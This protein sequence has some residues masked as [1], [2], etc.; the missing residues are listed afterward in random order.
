MKK[1]LPLILIA[2]LLLVSNLYSYDP[3]HKVDVAYFTDENS[4]DVLKTTTDWVVVEENEGFYKLY[5]SLVWQRQ[6]GDTGL[7]IYKNPLKRKKII[8]Y[9]FNYVGGGLFT[10][11]HEEFTPIGEV[12]IQIWNDGN[13]VKE[14]RL[15]Q[16]E[17]IKNLRIK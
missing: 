14:G 9:N 17:I 5:L 12:W 8:E 1:C 16:E 2:L 10:S 3:S 7:A 15:I 13:R 4:I 6:Y 11:S